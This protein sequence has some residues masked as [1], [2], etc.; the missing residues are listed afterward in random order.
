M[1]ITKR[2]ILYVL[3]MLASSLVVHAQ[4]AAKPLTIGFAQVGS[5]SAWRKAFTA[6]TE[7]EAQKRGINLV[8]VDSENSQEKEIAAL[9]SFIEQKVDAIILAPVVETG[10]DTVIKEINDAKIPLVIIDRNVTSDPSMY[11]T[12]IS[13]DFVFEGRLAAAWLVQATAGNCKIIELEGSIGS[14][15]ARDRQIGFNE[16]ISLF[17]NMEIVITESGDFQRDGGHDV[18]ES[19]LQTEDVSDV[20]A[21]W[22]HNDDMAI[23]AIQAMKD[24]GLKPGK[25]IKV[26]SVDAIPDI[27]KAMM[28]G[29]SNATVELSPYMAGPAFDAIND[30][31]A[32]KTVPKWIPVNG[33]I[34]FPDTAAEEYAKRSQQ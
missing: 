22:S 32:G 23:G 31:L 5:E 33:K 1:I 21:V 3:M 18:M 6:A 14:S 20:C 10:W 7:A 11:L 8:F 12:R 4:D 16:V 17:P 29:E 25:D 9:R 27:F 30:Y 24:Y 34:Y 28:D 26:V 15:A 2:I 13:S 19:I